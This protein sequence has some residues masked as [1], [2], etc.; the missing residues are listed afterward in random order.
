MRINVDRPHHYFLFFGN[1]VGNVVDYTDVIIADDT[2]G[3]T[4][5][6][7]SLSTPAGFDNTV[8]KTLT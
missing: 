7:C 3:D 2:K 8:T 1:N 5:L 6:G 4:I